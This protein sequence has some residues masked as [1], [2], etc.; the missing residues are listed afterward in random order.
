MVGFATVGPQFTDPKN[1]TAWDSLQQLSLILMG[2][3]AVLFLQ[4]G[5][6]TYFAW[7]YRSCR[8]PLILVMTSLFIAFILYLGLSF[9]FSL[10]SSDNAYLAWYVISVF[11]VGSMIAIAG[12]WQ[13]VSFKGTHLVERMT[14]LTLIIVRRHPFHIA[15]AEELTIVNSWE[16]ALL[17]LR[18]V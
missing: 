1:E 8:L 13:L 15:T 12:K 17:D 6:T 9:A 14:C 2:S 11:E 18:L 16:K 5:T 7:K 3:R 4:Y 10:E